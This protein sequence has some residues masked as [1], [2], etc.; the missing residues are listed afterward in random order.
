MEN[1]R[2]PDEDPLRDHTYDGIQEFDKRLPNWWLFTL[3]GAIA[4][5]FC[6]WFYNQ[7]IGVRDTSIEELQTELARIAT[8]KA[9]NSVETL[10]NEQLWRM[11]GDPAMLT[12]GSATYVSTCASCHGPDLEGKIGPSLADSVWIH[13][14]EPKNV[15]ATVA[16]GV[17]AKGMPAWGPVLGNKRVL[18]VVSFVMSHHHPPASEAEAGTGD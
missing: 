18:E 16:N 2:N 13:G 5:S 14:G 11:T 7:W 3:Y 6:Y 10:T 15:V 9:A 8:E 12:A 4:F 1:T 17:L